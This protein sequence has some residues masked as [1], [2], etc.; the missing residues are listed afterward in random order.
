MRTRY[1]TLIQ[2]HRFVLELIFEPRDLWLGVYWN[3]SY[4]YWEV[5]I[6]IIPT[7]PI[8]IRLPDP[9]AIPF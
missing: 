7:L 9:D 3:T 1:L 2:K 6:C 4:W 5:Y 8:H